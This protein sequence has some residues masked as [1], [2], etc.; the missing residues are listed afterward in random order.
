MDNAS[1][2]A[3]VTFGT[4]C[5]RCHDGECSGRLSFNL[6]V[7]A[8]TDHLMRH[9]GA[10]TKNSVRE[11]F[12]MLAFMKKECRY[13]PLDVPIPTDGIWSSAALARLCR[14]LQHSY[15]IPL[16]DLGV[17]ATRSSSNSE[18]SHTCTPR[19]SRGPSIC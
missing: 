18:T 7:E 8:S 14:P 9:A 1:V 2:D 13:P 4:T 16:G 12:A 17:A 6:G 15:F 5:A 11:L 19:S 3:A 10:L